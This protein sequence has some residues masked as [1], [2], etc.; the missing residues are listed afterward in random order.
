MVLW[1]GGAGGALQS[2]LTVRWMVPPAILKTPWAKKTTTC[3]SP[4]S[5]VPSLLTPLMGVR[6][7]EPPVGGVLLDLRLAG[8]EQYWY[9]CGVMLIPS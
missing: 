1:G 2:G 9:G 7:P 5:T 6:S 3:L 4:V 8:G